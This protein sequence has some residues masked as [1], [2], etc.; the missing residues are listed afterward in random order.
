MITQQQLLLFQQLREAGRQ[1]ETL[2][3]EILASLT[4]GSRGEPGASTATVRQ[5]SS[6][7][8]S[9]PIIE[10]LMGTSAV[11]NL[12]MRSYHHG[13]ASVVHH[14]R[15]PMAAT[16]HSNFTAIL[17]PIQKYRFDDKCRD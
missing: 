9:W 12:R 5:S 6:Q 2:R 15:C 8:L 11:D 14:A 10:Q 17:D 16:E 13:V 4:N 7:R 1:Y 3:L